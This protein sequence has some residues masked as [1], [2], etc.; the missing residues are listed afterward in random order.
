MS[1]RKL[2]LVKPIDTLFIAV[3]SQLYRHKVPLEQYHTHKNTSNEIPSTMKLFL[4]ICA[5]ILMCIQSANAFGML[6]T[7]SKSGASST[8]LSM[9]GN[10]DLLRFARASR[11]AG[12]DDN[13]VELMR[14]LG[15]VLNQDDDGNVYVE[16]FF[17][18]VL[19]F[20]HHLLKCGQL[21]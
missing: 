16:G 15:L 2:R 3:L 1:G 9:A 17:P 8:A 18:L 7:S 13:V 19:S 12:N 20:A 10:E 4:Q 14:P 11:S 21:G 5:A 6:A